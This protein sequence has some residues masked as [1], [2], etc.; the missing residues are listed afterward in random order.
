MQVRVYSLYYFFYQFICFLYST[1][2]KRVEIL[3]I[4]LYI[5]VIYYNYN[6]NIYNKNRYNK[7]SYNKNSYN[8]NIYNKNRYNKNRYNKNNKNSYNMYINFLDKFTKAIIAISFHSLKNIDSDLLKLFR[9]I[10]SIS[11]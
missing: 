5:I 1:I 8:K 6:K 9:Y 3:F 2:C 10:I 7:N 4:L 11:I